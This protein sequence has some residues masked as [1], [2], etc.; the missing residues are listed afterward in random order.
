MGIKGGSILKWKDSNP[1]RPSSSRLVLLGPQFWRGLWINRVM[2]TFSHSRLLEEVGNPYGTP[3]E[4]Y[5]VL[6]IKR[7]YFYLNIIVRKKGDEISFKIW[8]FHYVLFSELDSFRRRLPDKRILPSRRV[9]YS[10]TFWR[11]FTATRHSS[12]TFRISVC[13]CLYLT[14]LKSTRPT[15]QTPFLVRPRRKSFNGPC[16]FGIWGQV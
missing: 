4:V 12:L 10:Q 6:I 15:L 3:W 8:L 2:S 7:N 13:L 1:S 14:I 16:H 5:I 9:N 11:V